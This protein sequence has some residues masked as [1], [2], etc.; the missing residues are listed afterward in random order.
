METLIKVVGAVVVGVGMIALF[1]IVMA[2][3]TKWVADYLFSP[4]ALTAMFGAPVLSVWKAMA[5]NY[6]GG[7]IFKGSCSKK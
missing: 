7:A 2:Y 1:A 3:P 6:I 5:L 4:T